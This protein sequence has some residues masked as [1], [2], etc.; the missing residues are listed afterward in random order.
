[1][2]ERSHVGRSVPAAPLGVR[3]ATKESSMTL[4]RPRS[5]RTA[6]LAVTMGFLLLLPGARAFAAPGDLDPSFDS[7]GI[8]TTPIGTVDQAFDVAVDSSDRVIVGGF[9]YNGSD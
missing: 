9:A 1:M 4:H 5:V 2:S 3:L 8:A 7:D 6:V